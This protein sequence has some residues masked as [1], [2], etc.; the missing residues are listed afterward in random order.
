MGGLLMSSCVGSRQSFCLLP[1]IL[2]FADGNA[3]LLLFGVLIKSL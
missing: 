1:A 3:N 2:A